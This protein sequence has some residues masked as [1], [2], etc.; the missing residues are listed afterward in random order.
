M[1]GNLEEANACKPHISVLI[2][3]FNAERYVGD[4]LES[5]LCQTCPDSI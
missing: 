3:A 1:F 4:C 2:P 5:L